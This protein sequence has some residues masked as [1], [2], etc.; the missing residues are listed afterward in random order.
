MTAPACSRCV[1][2]EEALRRIVEVCECATGAGLFFYEG[3][4]RQ[5]VGVAREAL[6]GTPKEV[7]EPVTGECKPPATVGEECNPNAGRGDEPP[8]SLTSEVLVGT[9]E[10]DLGGDETSPVVEEGQS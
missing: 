8:G 5:C 9:R 3:V 7:S 6:V 2:L 1:L 10:K 4:V